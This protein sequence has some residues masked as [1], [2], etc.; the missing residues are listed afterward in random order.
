M[1]PFA[2]ASDVIGH[3]VSFERADPVRGPSG[4]LAEGSL[5][6]MVENLAAVTAETVAEG[7][8]PLVVGGDCAVLLGVLLGM[9]LAEDTVGLLFVDGHEDAWPPHESL[10]GDAADCE[11][12]IAVGLHH[13]PAALDQHMPLVDP[14]QVVVLGPR[15]HA[16]LSSASVESIAPRVRMVSGHDLANGDLEQI[17]ASAVAK[18]Q[19]R[20]RHWWLHVDLDV[21]STDALPAV[22]YP[23]SG[24]L[25]WA[26]LHELTAAAVGKGGC[27]GASVVIYNPD[28][29]QGTNAELIVAYLEN[30]VTAHQD[31]MLYDKVARTGDSQECQVPPTRR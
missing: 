22:D 1:R 19:Q 7:W 21:L 10:T 6:S 23:Q 15:D 20:S 29:D 5:V 8:W 3:Q 4:L 11:L 28:L 12:G 2:H 24:G 17:A 30:L 13:A 25:T 9:R 14:D 18:L 16:E 31:D 26:Q 27:V